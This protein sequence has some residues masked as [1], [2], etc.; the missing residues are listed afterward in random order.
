MNPTF[1][2][3]PVIV[4]GALITAAA[5]LLA[6]FFAAFWAVRKLRRDLRKEVQGVKYASTLSALQAFW[7]LLAYTTDT[8]N[9][10]SILRWKLNKG[11]GKTCFLRKKNA[12]DYVV[13]LAQTFYSEGHGLFLPKAIRAPFFEYR[14]ILYGVLLKTKDEPGEEVTLENASMVKRLLELHHEMTVALRDVLDLREPDLP[15]KP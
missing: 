6:P 1:Y 15:E 2:G 4:V 7:K 8:E 3:Q 14:S 10:K 13:A 11:D 5:S 12:H 9:E